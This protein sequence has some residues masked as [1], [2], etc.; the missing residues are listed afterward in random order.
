MNNATLIAL[1]CVGV[2]LLFIATSY[3]ARR[4][5]RRLENKFLPEVDFAALNNDVIRQFVLQDRETE[6]INAYQE[7]TGA[8]KQIAT[9]AIHYLGENILVGV[10]ESQ[11]PDDDKKKARRVDLEDA[12]GIRDLLEEGR[13]DEAV[14][15]YQKFAGVDAYTARDMVEKIKRE[16][17]GE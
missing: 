4:D 13:E 14:E 16:M 7:L 8:N 10:P 5:Q 15:V 17:G 12:P 3:A 11:L 1:I 2:A 6:A 9:Y